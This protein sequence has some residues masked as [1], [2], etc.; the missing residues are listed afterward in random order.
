[1]PGWASP[2]RCLSLCK[3]L[4]QSRPPDPLQCLLDSWKWEEYKYLDWSHPWPRSDWWMILLECA[5]FL[6][7]RFRKI[8]S[9]GYI[10]VGWDVLGR[11]EFYRFASEAS[12]GMKLPSC[13]VERYCSHASVQKRLA[14]LGFVVSRLYR[15]SR[16]HKT[17]FET[18]CPSWPYSLECGLVPLLSAQNWHV[19]LAFMPRENPHWW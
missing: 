12:P 16:L 10:H 18:A 17:L 13:Y 4:L 15:S 3:A 2:P 6:V 8:H 1:M 9:V 14:W 19:L 5:A 11:L 7:D